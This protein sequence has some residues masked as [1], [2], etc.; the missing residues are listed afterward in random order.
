MKHYEVR[1]KDEF[2]DLGILCGKHWFLWSARLHLR[3]A[4]QMREDA[5][6]KQGWD[7]HWTYYIREVP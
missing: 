6:R 1:A 2:G 4:E 7:T 5:K 3:Q